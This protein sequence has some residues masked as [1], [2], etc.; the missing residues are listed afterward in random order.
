MS[1]AF[2]RAASLLGSYPGITLGLMA[3]KKVTIS[4]DQDLYAWARRRAQERGT[5]LSARITAALRDAWR[6]EALDE[7]LEWAE[8]NVDVPD[9]ART[10]AED[11]LDEA[12]RPGRSR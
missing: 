9:E 11:D 7:Y 12:L 3:V 10:S 4:L 8:K 5:T 1:S 2:D 6:A